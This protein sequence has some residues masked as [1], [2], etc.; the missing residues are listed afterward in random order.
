LVRPQKM[1]RFHVIRA[2]VRRAS[3]RWRGR[4]EGVPTVVGKPFVRDV[5]FAHVAM[6]R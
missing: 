1:T 4:A 3:A 6:L 2:A 5:R